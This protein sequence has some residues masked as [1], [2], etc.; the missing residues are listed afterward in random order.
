MCLSDPLPQYFSYYSY[1]NE[2]V[3]DRALACTCAIAKGDMVKEDT[4][5]YVV[6]MQQALMLV[7]TGAKTEGGRAR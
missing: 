2:E 4:Y 3:C 1:T 6:L 7:V 5:T